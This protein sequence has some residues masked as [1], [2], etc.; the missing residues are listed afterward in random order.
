MLTGLTN[1]LIH[2]FTVALCLCCLST[3]AYSGE[4]GAVYFSFI[5]IQIFIDIIILLQN[6]IFFNKKYIFLCC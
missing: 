3:G 1:C 2:E 6:A 4:G 5:L